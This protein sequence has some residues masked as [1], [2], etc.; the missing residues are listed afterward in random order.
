MKLKWIL[1]IFVAIASTVFL[2]LGL[3]KSTDFEPLI[4][5]KLVS[6]VSKAFNGLYKLQI[7]K[8][9]IDVL[10]ATATVGDVTLLPDTVSIIRKS[11][12]CINNYW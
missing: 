12:L 4:K 8:I 1:L 9:E 11:S 6:L 7:G 5:A 10:Q 3:R 2:Y